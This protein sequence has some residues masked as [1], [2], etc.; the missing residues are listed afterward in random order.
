MLR[1]LVA[2]A[3]AVAAGVVA[4]LALAF[5]C[6]LV[7]GVLRRDAANSAAFVA[8]LTILSPL[9]GGMVAH[10]VAKR[11]PFLHGMLVGVALI[12]A[13]GQLA[14]VSI[15]PVFVA[16]AGAWIASRATP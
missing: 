15:A 10:A 8:T 4:A 14:G 6:G 16:M 9:F 7:A 1:E 2:G 5:T 3:K 11:L 12:F 13:G